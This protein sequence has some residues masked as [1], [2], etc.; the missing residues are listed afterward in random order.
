MNNKHKSCK[1]KK[2]PYYY[3]ALCPYRKSCEYSRDAVWREV[4]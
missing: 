1:R 4:K 2:C 3:F